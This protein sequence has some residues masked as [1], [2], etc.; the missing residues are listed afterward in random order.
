VAQTHE[1]RG[2][3]D[4]GSRAHGLT[5]WVKQVARHPAFGRDWD[6]WCR[7]CAVTPASAHDLWKVFHTIANADPIKNPTPAVTIRRM[8]ALG[9]SKGSIT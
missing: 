5:V 3:V 8:A 1:I 9:N 7:T 2:L 6:T 4:S